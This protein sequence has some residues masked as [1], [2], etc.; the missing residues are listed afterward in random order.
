MSEKE[1]KAQEIK[2]AWQWVMSGEQGRMV[3]RD[4][5]RISGYGQSPFTG[6]TNT[7]I[8]NV[9]MQDV[10][11]IV[12]MHA[13]QYAFDDWLKLVKEEHGHG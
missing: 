10:A 8:K 1:K 2:E 3:I 4:I 6:Q 5:L 13:R 11:R 7:V 9:G 12:E